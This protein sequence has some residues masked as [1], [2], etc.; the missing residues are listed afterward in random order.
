MLCIARLCLIAGAFILPLTAAQAQTLRLFGDSNTACTVGTGQSTPLVGC[1]AAL[2]AYE[3]QSLTVSYAASGA[4]VIPQASAFYAVTPN[5][6]DRYYVMLGTNDQ[7]LNGTNANKLA[8][9]TR[10]YACELGKLALDAKNARTDPSWSFT[11]AWANTWAYGIGKNT[12]S[13]GAT[14][15]FQ[16]TGTQVRIC[17]IMQDG[18]SG[19]ASV[20][21]DGVAMG[22]WS[23]TGATSIG[24]PGYAPTAVDIT[25]LSPGTHTVVITHTSGSY[26]YLDWWAS[27]AATRNITVANVMRMT[28]AGYASYGGSDANVATYNTTIAG[29]IATLNGTFG[30]TIKSVDIHAAIDPATDLLGDGIHLNQSGHWLVSSGFEAVQ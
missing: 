30:A 6:S 11:G 19:L 16:F 9:F 1:W 14:A 18:Q 5:T 24:S 13:V 8:N 2:T 20:A 29:L 4:T 28:A 3:T 7:R 15:S 22:F 25:G 12:T 10:I 23:F 27:A 26:V 21:V 17:G